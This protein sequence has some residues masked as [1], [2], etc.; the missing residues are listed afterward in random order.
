MADRTFWQSMWALT[1]LAAAAL[2][3]LLVLMLIIAYFADL[4]IV[5]DASRGA[6]DYEKRSISIVIEQEPPQMDSTRATDAVSGMLLGHL[7]EGLLRYDG[8]GNLQPGVAESW[9]VTPEGAVFKL[10]E[11]ARWSDGEPVTAHDFVFSWRKALEPETA[12]LYAFIMYPIKHAEAINL[13]DM[14]SDQLG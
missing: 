6:T 11:N 7:M 12:S 1:M 8:E 2:G 3:G 4:T 9:T 14:P 13:G 5:D 10:R